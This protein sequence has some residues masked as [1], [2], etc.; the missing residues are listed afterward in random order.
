MAEMTNLSWCLHCMYPN[1]QGQRCLHCGT[2]VHEV[3][4]TAPCLRPG[5][6]LQGGKYLVGRALGQGGFGITY[7]GVHVALNKRVAIK[8]YYPDHLAR[9]R[10]G[11]CAVAPKPDPELEALYRQGLEQFREEGR[12][13]VQFMH[14]NIVRASDY[15]EE[16]GTAY[17]VMDY[18]D[19]VSLQKYLEQHGNRISETKAL[20]LM[21]PVMDGLRAVHKAGFLHRDVKP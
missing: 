19:G 9:T 17:L 10:T 2:W 13:I 7:L 6:T 21:Q 18:V 15:F 12:R 3:G 4:W 8:E 16:N 1:M 11:G 20:Q 5:V 14:P